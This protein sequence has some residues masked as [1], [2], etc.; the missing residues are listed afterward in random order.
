M[1]RSTALNLTYITAWD[2]KLVYCGAEHYENG[3]T[4]LLQLQALGL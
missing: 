1:N 2:D 4:A 3:G